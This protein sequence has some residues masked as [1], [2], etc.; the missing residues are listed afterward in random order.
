MVY[1]GSTKDFKAR[2]K[3]HL[4]DLFNKKHHNYKLQKDFDKFGI[5]SF[6]FEIVQY[7]SNQKDMLIHEYQLINSIS[8]VYNIQKKD[9]TLEGN[10][11]DKN[12][13]VIV[14]KT[15]VL[16]VLKKDKKIPSNKDSGKAY[17]KVCKLLSGGGAKSWQRKYKRNGELLPMQTTAHEAFEEIRKKELE[18][19]KKERIKKKIRNK[20]YNKNNS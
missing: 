6:K 17:K 4:E 3:Q 16:I 2:K 11:N 14:Q 8:K 12:G 18:E 9:Y 10:K 15:R 13:K 1:F 19:I 7:F 5:Q 20:K